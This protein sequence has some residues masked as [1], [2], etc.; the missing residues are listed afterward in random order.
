[1]SRPAAKP[2]DAPPPAKDAAMP[3]KR[4]D[5]ARE[6]LESIVV[7][8]ILAFLFRTFIAEAFV[9]PT[10]SMAPTLFGRHK[11]V[12]CPQ[13]G[14]HFEVGA[15][16]ELDEEGVRLLHRIRSATCPN[17]RFTANVYDLP[18]FK[19]DRILVNKFPYEVGELN[20]W[21][22][23]VFKYPEL[24]ERN[25]IKRLV[26]L[27][28]ETIRI[29]RG[30]VYARPAGAAAFHILRKD[31]PDK[32]NVL[33]ILVY[34]DTHP[35]RKLIAAGWPERWAAMRLDHGPGAIDGWSVHADDVQ[36]DAAARTYTFRGAGD[37]RWLRYRHLVPS[38]LDWESVQ[39]GLRPATNPRPQLITDYYA[40]NSSHRGVNDDVFWVGDLTL[41]GVVDVRQVA[42]DGA[43]LFEL[44]EG[45]RRYRCQ[46]DLNTGQATLTHTNELQPEGE[47]VLLGTAAT[48]VSGPGRYRFT[49][50]N[51][52]DR[53]CLWVN[54]KVVQLEG[55]GTYHP[56]ALLDP[57]D[58]DLL[59][60]GIAVRGAD[61]Q[62]G[63][64]TLR[65]DIYYRAERVDDVAA[66]R[67][68]AGE[69]LDE[70][71]K[72]RLRDLLSSPSEY[73]VLY[74]QKAGPVEF[75]ELRP[76]EFF[77]MGDNSPRSQ[78]SRLWSNKRGAVNRHAV[79]RQ[80]MVGKAFIIYWPHGIPFLNDGKGYGIVPHRVGNNHV[81]NYPA[82]TVPFYPQGI[83]P[84]GRLFARIR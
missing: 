18:V 77:V 51:V 40:Y 66:F 82:Y 17:C 41:S 29:N 64:L 79:P 19:G 14:H 38:D 84:F 22:V 67:T 52:D 48:G 28:G 5:T 35:P 68:G 10:G 72:S 74:N 69:D 37:W 39:E 2:A 53:V 44:V 3:P 24:P 26:G 8:F 27:P 42:G 32:Q 58:A 56:S 50:A 71:T 57:Q 9:I 63:Q 12:V 1:M 7:A 45:I 13:C 30:D 70:F 83:T 46:I 21:D 16:E 47:P 80:A 20:R 33:Q 81:E 36:A 6:T 55:Q 61:V 73:A 78:D 25:Y 23:C 54:N 60:A 43:L 34:D 59:P 62:L 11:D 76:N 49:W 31:D 65:R 4:Q 75:S 15:S